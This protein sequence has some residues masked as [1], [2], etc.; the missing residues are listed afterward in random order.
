MFFAVGEKR[1]KLLTIKEVLEMSKISRYTLYKDIKSGKIKT[2]CL[3][4]NIRIKE[5]DAVEYAKAKEKSVFVASY[6]K[7]MGDDGN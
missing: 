2:V 5:S 3:G 7:R 6:R 4:K 1:D